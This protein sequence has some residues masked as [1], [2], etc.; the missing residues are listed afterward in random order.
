[1]PLLA[2]IAT[3]LLTMPFTCF[4]LLFV[5]IMEKFGS[6]REQASWV[7]SAFIMSSNLSALAIAFLQRRVGLSRI[8]LISAAATSATVRCVCIRSEHGLDERHLRWSLWFYSEG[9]LGVRFNLHDAVLRQVPGHRTV[10]HQLRS[11][12]SWHG[13]TN[14]AFAAAE[15]LRPQRSIGD[16]RGILMNASS[17]VYA[18]QASS[19]DKVYVLP[20]KEGVRVCRQCCCY[21]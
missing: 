20:E 1:M 13:G 18:A 6:T 2:S 7:E 4:G 11:G 16:T 15:G 9:V 19:P 3:F 14:P 10:L 17:T 8:A 12:S 21:L 5:L